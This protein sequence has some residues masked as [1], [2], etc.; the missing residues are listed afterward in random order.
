MEL[1]QFSTMQQELQNE[2]NAMEI[3]YSS[4]ETAKKIADI[5]EELTQ[6]E[7]LKN[8]LTLYQDDVNQWRSDCWPEPSIEAAKAIL[9]QDN[10]DNEENSNTCGCRTNALLSIPIEDV[11]DFNQDIKTS[12]KDY[13]RNITLE[14]VKQTETPYGLDPDGQI[15]AVFFF[16]DSI[17]VLM[18]SVANEQLALDTLDALFSTFTESQSPDS[19]NWKRYLIQIDTEPDLH[20]N[21]YL[22]AENH[23]VSLAVTGTEDKAPNHILKTSDHPFHQQNF[24]KLA[25][26]T[27]LAAKFNSSSLAKVLS[28]RPFSTI[29]DYYWQDEYMFDDE[30]IVQMKKWCE[31]EEAQGRNPCSD[32]TAQNYLPQLIHAAEMSSMTD[33]ECGKE[34]QDLFINYPEASASV[35]LSDDG[36]LSMIF[37][38]KLSSE[39]YEKLSPILTEH[40]SYN[41]TFDMFNLT[42]GLNLNKAWELVFSEWA[43]LSAKQWQCT[44]IQQ[45][46][47]DNNE[48]MLDL[49]AALND[50]REIYDIVSGFK[51][52]NLAVQY[53]NMQKSRNN[54]KFILSI[55]DSA[56]KSAFIPLLRNSLDLEIASDGTFSIKNRMSKLHGFANDTSLLAVPEDQD[57]K[58]MKPVIVPKESI[59]DMNITTNAI[60]EILNDMIDLENPDIVRAIVKNP[61]FNLSVDNDSVIFRIEEQR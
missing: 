1:Q 37:S 52:A 60:I 55:T 13:I 33:P 59:F 36:L 22:K 7:R 11:D 46:I 20:L 9:A 6:L 51:G 54:L 10:C 35:S 29:I 58:S 53:I 41:N 43:S 50:N 21:I 8:Q 26:S 28:G 39:Q 47:S 24:G 44:Q 5:S 2:L 25:S 15:D 49:M 56:M 40:P 23:I 19:S 18:Y 48:K 3:N 45:M 61:K 34:I 57:Y 38:Q 30:K 16:S 27:I 4:D 31:D 17:P 32:D 14:K 12:M 42:L